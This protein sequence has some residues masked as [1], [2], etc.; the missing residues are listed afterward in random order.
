MAIMYPETINLEET[1]SEAEI[2]VFNEL[3]EK[4]DS[5]WTIFHSV[6][7][8][9]DG[10]VKQSEGECDFI[11]INKDYGILIIEVKGG[12]VSSANGKWYSINRYNEKV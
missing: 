3:K 10:M 6:K 4:L 11:L 8:I 5:T 1:I 12:K 2:F 7:W 9:S